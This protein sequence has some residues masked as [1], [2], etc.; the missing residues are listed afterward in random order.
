MNVH[1]F[2]T[3]V[4]EREGIRIV[5]RAPEHT[6]VGEYDYQRSAAENQRLTEWLEGRIYPRTG[7]YG[8]V[9]IDGRGEIP[10]G[11]NHLSTVRQT[12]RE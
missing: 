10:H 12:Y 9:V 8:I 4:W 6:N 5:I 1:E 11:K 2:E 3:A 7:E